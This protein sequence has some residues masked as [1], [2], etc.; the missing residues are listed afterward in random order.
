MMDYEIFKEM[1]EEKFMDY[2]P[3]EYQDMKVRIQPINKINSTLDGLTIIPK[4]SS[5]QVI[6]PN[7]YINHMYDDY[8]INND[9]DLTLQKFAKSMENGFS[10]APKIPNIKDKD[11]VKDNITFQLINTLQNEE[12]LKNVPF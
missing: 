11:Q 7:I 9:L 2:M 8:C 1:V 12:M 3:S 5:G 10:I 4:E 6:S